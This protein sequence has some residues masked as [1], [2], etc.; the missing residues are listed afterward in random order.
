MLILSMLA[1]VF[2]SCKKEYSIENVGSKGELPFGNWQFSEGGTDFAG[3]I[4]T[5]YIKD[6]GSIKEMHLV[7][8]SND[9]TQGFHLVIFAN[10]FVPGSYKASAYQSSFEYGSA[11]P[12]LYSAS[13]LTGEFIVNI[14]SINE[15][16]ITGTFSGAALKNGQDTV[17]V[18]T[19]L[20][21]SVLKDDNSAPTSSGVLGD[22]NGNC[23][24]VTI[25][26]VYKQGIIMNPGNTIVVEVT[27]AVAGTYHI[28]TD[29]VNGVSFSAS[30]TFAQAGTQTV[31][32]T[33]A[34]IPEQ[35]GEKQFAVHF[36]NSQCAFNVTFELGAAPSGDY[37]PLT[38]Q[39]NWLYTDGLDEE[40]TKVT[41]GTFSWNGNN[42]NVIGVYDNLN[43]PNPVDTFAVIRKGS[44]LYYSYNDF[45][46][47]VQSSEPVIVEN[48]FLKDNVAQ[49]TSWDGPEF[50]ATVNSITVKYHF[51]FTIK[52]KAVPASIGTFNFPDVI[53]V[54]GQLYSGSTYLGI[55]EERWYAKNVGLIYFGGDISGTWT[56]K[57]FQ[58]F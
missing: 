57:N 31:T 13:Q 24:P 26:G 5:T 41:G 23:Q 16:L 3:T 54:T 11:S 48:I 45:S 50:S 28:Y 49:G 17:Q 6:G 29:V 58:V 30:G 36:G 27:V 34:G 33:G 47:L 32:L 40:L 2:T 35:E 1:A 55:Q 21:K 44:G 15:E 38:N 7:G 19:G 56:V 52:E 37:Y 22:N 10:D 4:D 42:Y 14:T 39:S 53:K 9:G 18:I 8:K 43:D 12:L 51:K 25:N 46:Q 20:F